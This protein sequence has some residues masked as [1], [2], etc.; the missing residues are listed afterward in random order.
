MKYNIDLV[1][2]TILE[3]IIGLGAFI[4]GIIM[5]Q[6]PT[7]KT[8]FKQD[9]RSY[10]IL[11]DFFLPGLFLIIAFGFGTLIFLA[12]LWL[13]YRFAW[14]F[15]VLLSITEL[16]WIGIQIILLYSVGL[17]VWQVIIPLIAL[18]ALIFLLINQN[19]KKF[20]L[21]GKIILAKYGI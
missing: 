5:I 17:I 10:I 16:I 13:N 20:Y 3:L 21:N 1:I 19:K 9:L 4:G 18:I 15:G 6:D 2:F 7:G 14:V 12:G 11:P 8:M